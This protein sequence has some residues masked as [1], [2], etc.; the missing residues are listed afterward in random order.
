[1]AVYDGFGDW[2]D[3]QYEFDMNDPE[4][5]NVIFASYE[6]GNYDGW[7]TV[8]WIT[9]DGKIG[10]ASGSHCSCHG[11]EGQWDPEF[12]TKEMF[13]EMVMRGRGVLY[14]YRKEI[15]EALS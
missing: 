8:C 4:P 2:K 9:D 12:Y 3:V 14:A 1:M 7:A 13:H 15:R 11:L 5:A 10:Y 6:G